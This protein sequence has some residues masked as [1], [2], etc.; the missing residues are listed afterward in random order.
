[1]A[2]DEPPGVSVAL[3]G[4]RGSGKSTLG[5]DLAGH[6]GF[7]FVDTDDDVLGRFEESSFIEI[8]QAHGE[9]AWRSAELSVAGEL[10]GQPDR[11]LAMGGGMP[12][13]PGV[14]ES[15]RGAKLAG[16][17]IV[18]YLA[19]EPAL[20]EARL[21]AV[22]GDRSSLTGHGLIEEIRVLHEER[23]QI[24]RSLADIICPVCDESAHETSARLLGLIGG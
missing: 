20:L 1:V 4:L 8:M 2:H 5:P 22:P 9:A 19:A 11:V 10:I 17:L 18:I 7:Q 21:A 6:L 16:Q 14:Q 13:I 3:I 15:I 23:D 24:Y 12:C